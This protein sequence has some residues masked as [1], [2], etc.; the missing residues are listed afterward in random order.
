MQQG[1]RPRGS[2]AAATQADDDSDA[3]RAGAG[4]RLRDVDISALSDADLLAAAEAG[5]QVLMQGMHPNKPR[6]AW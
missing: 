3:A 1:G 6:N 2:R 5:V 4:V